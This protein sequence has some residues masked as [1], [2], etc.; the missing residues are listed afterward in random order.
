MGKYGTTGWRNWAGTYAVTLTDS[1]SPPTS[2]SRPVTCSLVKKAV[3][4]T[5]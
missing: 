4:C 1:Q 3:R 5:T 2:A